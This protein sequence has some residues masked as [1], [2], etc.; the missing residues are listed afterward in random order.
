MN[1]NQ[2]S[3][4]ASCLFSFVLVVLF[5]SSASAAW[6]EKVLY[7][8]Q[9]GNDGATPAGGVVF[10]SAGNLYGVTADGGTSCPPPGCGTVF[11]LAPSAKKGGAWTETVLHV[12]DGKDGTQPTGG[13]ILDLKGNL[14]GVTGYGGS[15]NCQLLGSEVGCGLIYK[16]SLPTKKG[17]KWT[18]S[19]LYSFLGGKDGQYPSGN[20][21]FDAVG[22]LYGATIYGG[23]FQGTCNAPYYLYCGT[24]FK[25]S[26][27]TK[28][29]GEWKEKVLHS[30]KGVKSG[31]DSGDGAS[32]NG[33]LV[34]DS[35]GAI[36]GTTYF[37]GNN[38]KGQCEGGV[39]GTGCGIVYKLSPPVSKGGTWTKNVLHQFDGEDGANPAAGVVFDGTGNLY[40]TTFAGPPNGSGLAFELKKPSGSVHSWTETVLHAFSDGDD[41]ANP[42][43]GLIFDVRGD[44]YGTAYRGLGGSQYGDVFRLKP[45]GGKRRWTLSTLYGFH[46]RPGPGQ[47][48]AGLAF[49]DTG[50]VYGTSQYGGTGQACQGD[51]GTVFE[52]S[53]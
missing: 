5:S 6:K 31:Q 48:A 16:L 9:G 21:V 46:T 33:G 8:F 28:K 19:I 39:A 27:P 10:D 15:G 34:L 30:F 24:V 53:P 41:G 47:P 51:C 52:V 18:Y 37:G 17:G 3:R 7:S 42:A 11:Q 32:P 4:L 14:Y 50:N 43:A 49:D 2:R 23:G 1:R 35:K 36:Y 22:N 26:P 13:L 40:G 38:V 25:L 29:A 12:F 44:L 20:L 45:P